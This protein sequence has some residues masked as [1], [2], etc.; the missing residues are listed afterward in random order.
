MKLKMFFGSFFFTLSS[1]S[2]NEDKLKLKM[3][4]LTCL[5]LVICFFVYYEFYDVVMMVEFCSLPKWKCS[6]PK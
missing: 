3:V 5:V 1:E 2:Q 6:F 4:V